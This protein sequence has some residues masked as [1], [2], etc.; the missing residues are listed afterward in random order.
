MNR[1]V[2]SYGYLDNLSHIH[3][4]PWSFKFLFRNS[5][6]RDEKIKRLIEVIFKRA[7]MEPIMNHEHKSKDMSLSFPTKWETFIEPKKDEIIESLCK[8]GYWVYNNYDDY[9]VIAFA[10]DYAEFEVWSKG[11]DKKLIKW[12]E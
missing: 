8:Q 5:L 2:L 7:T 12:E 1:C 10:I 4:S 6:D 11:R 9:Y 3:A